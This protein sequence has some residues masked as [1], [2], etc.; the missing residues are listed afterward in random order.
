MGSSICSKLKQKLFYRFLFRAGQLRIIAFEWIYLS[1]T[2]QVCVNLFSNLTSQNLDGK[3]FFTFAPP[4]E[5]FSPAEADGKKRRSGGRSRYWA[6]TGFLP[7]SRTFGQPTRRDC[8]GQSMD[9]ILFDYC[10]P[11]TMFP[12]QR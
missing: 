8:L 1:D 9:P 4:V 6:A 3:L 10:R 12:A 7:A 2:D 5:R 11:M